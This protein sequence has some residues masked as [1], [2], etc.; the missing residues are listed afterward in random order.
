MTFRFLPGCIKLSDHTPAQFPSVL[1]LVQVKQLF[2]CKMLN[3]CANLNSQALGTVLWQSLKLQFA[4]ASLEVGRRQKRYA[5]RQHGTP[6][7]CSFVPP[8]ASGSPGR[9]VCAPRLDVKL[10]FVSEPL[11]LSFSPDI[12]SIYK[13]FMKFSSCYLFKEELMSHRFLKHLLPGTI[14][15]RH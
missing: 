1:N 10:R 6:R 9:F 13:F 2:T 7:K 14:L 15:L 4:A 5:S 11:T 8:L 12:K 3:T